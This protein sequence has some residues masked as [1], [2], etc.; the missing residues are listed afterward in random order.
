MDKIRIPKYVADW[1]DAKVENGDSLV[2]ALD[3]GRQIMPSRVREWLG[4]EFNDEVFARAWLDGYK[5]GNVMHSL[6]I[7]P[8]FFKAV[9]DGSK[10][11][12]IRKN[13]RDYCVGD[14]LLLCEYDSLYMR[15]TGEGL[16]F[17]ITYMT[18]YAQ[19]AGYVVLGIKEVKK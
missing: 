18:S 7:A 19:K 15:H 10:N 13:D 14:T 4:I 6:K 1:I 17:E 12:E 9:K 2:V 5:S 11:F 3:T 16:L 8:E